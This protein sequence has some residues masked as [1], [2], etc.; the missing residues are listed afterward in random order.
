MQGGGVD[1][2]DYE[3]YSDAVLQLGRFLNDVSM[4]KRIHSS[5]GYLTPAEFAVCWRCEREQPLDVH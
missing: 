5:L 3:C 2:S 4:H 1:L